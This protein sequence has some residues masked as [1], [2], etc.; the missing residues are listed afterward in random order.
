MFDSRG[1]HH[2]H[3]GY[4]LEPGTTECSLCPIGLSINFFAITDSQDKNTNRI[5]FDARDDAK[6]SD[7]EFPDLAQ[8]GSYES[9]PW[10]V[11][12]EKLFQVENEAETV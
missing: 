8:F 9:L 1:G 5:I 4:I 7:P 12:L 2:L 10:N 11:K 6:I 3:T